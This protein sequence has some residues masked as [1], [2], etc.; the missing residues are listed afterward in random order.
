MADASPTLISSPYVSLYMRRN[1]SRRSGETRW[2][3]GG[4]SNN[5]QPSVG[6]IVGARFCHLG[7]SPTAVLRNVARSERAVTSTA[8]AVTVAATICKFTLMW[9]IE[10]CNY[11]LCRVLA[12]SMGKTSGES[13]EQENSNGRPPPTDHSMVHSRILSSREE[14]WLTGILVIH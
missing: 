8:A 4:M 3:V 11:E 7:Y 2:P 1:S 5:D 10:P 13:A 6:R 14:N 12:H 9:M